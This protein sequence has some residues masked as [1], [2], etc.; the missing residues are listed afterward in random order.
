MDQL[1]NAAAEERRAKVKERKE[2]ERRRQAECLDMQGAIDVFRN[3]EKWLDRS[4]AEVLTSLT[5]SGESLSE[6]E[7]KEFFNIVRLL[8]AAKQTLRGLDGRGKTSGDA[9]TQRRS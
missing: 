7:K 3:A 9:T 1:W 8:K 5:N 4:V 6:G 2:A